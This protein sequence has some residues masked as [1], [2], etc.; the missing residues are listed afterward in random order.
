MEEININVT[1]NIEEVEINVEPNVTQVIINEVSGSGGVQSVTGSL[2]DNT[3]PA[4]PV[5]NSD[6]TQIPLQ[7][8]EVTL[9]DLGVSTLAEVT[10]A[11]VEAYVAT[12]DLPIEVNKLFTVRVVDG[13]EPELPYLRMVF[14]DID[15]FVT[16]S[17][18]FDKN[19]LEDW[20]SFISTNYYTSSPAITADFTNLEI[21]GNEVV[22]T[23]G[24]ENLT[25]T[26][27]LGLFNGIGNWFLEE[28]EIKNF[29]SLLFLGVTESFNNPIINI[30][31]CTLINYL[32]LESNDFTASR[33]D[34]NFA[35]F[36]N[37]TNVTDGFLD[38]FVNA[39]DLSGT[40][41]VTELT[42]K[43]WTINID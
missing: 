14:D 40:V 43:G 22:L 19:D 2:V 10:T 5:V 37:N 41:T 7:V 1:K 33:F 39:E 18:A 16:D 17:G 8:L 12:L 11:V 38:A 3:D 32:N 21:N 6:A 25:L 24:I 31:N 9:S 30:E 36:A 27:F 42:A 28:F 26:Q 15:A 23:G 4:N 29:T 20:N 35:T 13:G 34:F